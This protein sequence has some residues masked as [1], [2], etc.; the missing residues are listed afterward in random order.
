ML[1]GDRGRLVQVVLNLLQNAITYASETER[2]DVRLSRVPAA[3]EQPA[4]GDGPAGAGWAQIEVQDYGSGI[5][6]EDLPSLFTRFFQ[7]ARPDRPA[8]GGLGLGL[9][10]SKQIVE[11]H[12]GTITVDSVVGQGSTFTVRLPLS[13]SQAGA[14]DQRP[15]IANTPGAD[16]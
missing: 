2:I 9:F 6:P 8:R 5:P 12:G 13:T 14:G 10:I 4:G 15:E 1:S 11:Q 16:S 3:E 7:V